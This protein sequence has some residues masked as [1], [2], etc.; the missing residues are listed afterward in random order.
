MLNT[1]QCLQ[2]ALIPEAQGISEI[3]T[4]EQLDDYAF[5]T[6]PK[7]YID[8]GFCT[9]PPSDWEEVV[10]IVGIKTMFGSWNAIKIEAEM[11]VDCGA[12]YLFLVSQGV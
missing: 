8:N 3:T 4:C 2:E 9:L 6:H 11:A 7:C 1:M 10:K 12:L 5:S